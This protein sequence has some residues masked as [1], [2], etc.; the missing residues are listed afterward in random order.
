V[1]RLRANRDG[2]DADNPAGPAGPTGPTGTVRPSPLV[3]AATDPA[4]PFGATLPWPDSNGRPARAA[5]AH[6]VIDDGEPMAFLERSGKRL[7][8]FRPGRDRAAD[9]DLTWLGALT[10]LLERRRYRQIELAQIDGAAAT[11][12]PLAPAL[13]AVGFRDGYRGLVLRTDR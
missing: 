7:V 13:R 10:Q 1:D 4:Q 2:H 12:S 5:G 8:T 6:V 3:L 11:E 9:G